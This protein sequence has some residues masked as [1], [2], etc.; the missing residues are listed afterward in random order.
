[1]LEDQLGPVR[2]LLLG[3]GINDEIVKKYQH[4]SRLH[5]VRKD[6]GDGIV[7]DRSCTFDTFGH[8]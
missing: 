8:I 2:E 3:I 6:L 5:K 7:K 4:P 1:L